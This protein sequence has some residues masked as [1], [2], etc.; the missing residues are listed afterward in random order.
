MATRT[1]RKR[2]RSNQGWFKK[3]FDPRRHVF[4]RQDC[5]LGYVVCYM[6]HPDLRRWLRLRVRCY[7]AKRE[8]EEADCPF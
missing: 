4:T 7:G 2:R 3:G 6:K 5:W 1:P 8:R